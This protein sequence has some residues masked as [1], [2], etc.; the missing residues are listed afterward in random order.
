MANTGRNEPCPCGSGR[1]TKRCC[2][3]TSG[4]S[5]DQLAQA[6]LVAKAREWAVLLLGHSDADLDDVLAD[7]VAL[8]RLDLSLHVPLPRVFTPELGRARAAVA[9]GDAQAARAAM[10]VVLPLFDTPSLR[11][12]LARAVIALHDDGHRVDCAVT[13]YAVIDLADNRP[14]ALLTA[15][16]IEALAVSSGAVPTPAGLVLAGV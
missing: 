3:T 4:P 9:R 10:T 11:A 7:V 14:S 6:W 1:K 12:D 13:A 15:A 8:P 5:P 16:L 2:G